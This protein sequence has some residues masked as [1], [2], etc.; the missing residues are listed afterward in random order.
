MIALTPLDFL[1]AE[2]YHPDFAEFN[3]LLMDKQVPISSFSC[4]PASEVS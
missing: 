1:I 2:N 3:A 4:A